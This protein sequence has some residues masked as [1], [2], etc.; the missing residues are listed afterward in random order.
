MVINAVT[1]AKTQLSALLDRVANGEEVILGRAGKPVAILTPYREEHRP[2][3]PG[4]LRGK[5]H[6]SE[7]FDD[8]PAEFASAFGADLS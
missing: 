6:I 7:D 3:R 1:E 5:I 2:R 8:L 4:R